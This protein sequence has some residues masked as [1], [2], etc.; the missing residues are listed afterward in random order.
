MQKGMVQNKTNS[1]NSYAA[2]KNSPVGQFC[3]HISKPL[4]ITI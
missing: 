3:K 4:K 1:Q 2:Y